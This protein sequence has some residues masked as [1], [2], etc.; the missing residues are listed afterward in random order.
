MTQNICLKNVLKYNL[1]TRHLNYYKENF[2][3]FFSPSIRMSGKNINFSD[4]KINKS[5]FYKYKKLFKVDEIVEIL[6][7][8]KEAYGT[9]NSLK[10]F[11]GYN[12]D[13]VIRLLCIKLP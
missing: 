4:K 9:K 6:V 10:Y 13:A 2:T 7:S 11:I 5:H 1:F 8:R 3:Y 12:D